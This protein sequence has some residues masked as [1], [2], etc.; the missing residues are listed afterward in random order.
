MTVDEMIE[1]LKWRDGEDPHADL[2]LSQHFCTQVIAALRAGQQMRENSPS[3]WECAKAWDRAVKGGRMTDYWRLGVTGSR[4]GPTELQR[5]AFEAI[6]E[7]VDGRIQLRHGS[8]Y[9]VDAFC[10]YHVLNT[11]P[12]A[13]RR[14]I[15]HPCNIAEWTSVCFNA[16]QSM[17]PKPPLERNRDIV[18][19]SDDIIAMPK[20]MEEEQRSGTWATVRYARKMG[21]KVTVIWPDGSLG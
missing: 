14:I 2:L 6:I 5:R 7:E 12:R 15:R 10:H 13:R 9:G 18:F 1:L 3:N 21:K 16:D 17:E 4:E 20:T 8:C 19:W 11:V